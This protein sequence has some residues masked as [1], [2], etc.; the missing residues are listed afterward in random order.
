MA[1]VPLQPTFRIHNEVWNPL[2]GSERQMAGPRYVAGALCL[3]SVDGCKA[4]RHACTAQYC[5]LS[6]EQLDEGR[7]W[8]FA[9]K[10]KLGLKMPEDFQ[11][12]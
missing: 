1:Q 10:G 6:G 11:T 7:T 8:Y 4:G 3:T 9:L 5:L 12:R 2:A